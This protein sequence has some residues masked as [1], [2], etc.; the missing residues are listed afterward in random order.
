VLRVAD[1]GPGIPEAERARVFERF[2]Q[3]VGRGSHGLGLAFCKLVAEAHHGRIWIEDANP[4]AVFCVRVP[5]T[6]E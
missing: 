1:H 2:E 5:D 3:G 6:P 4:G